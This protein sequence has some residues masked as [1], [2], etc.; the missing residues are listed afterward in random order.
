ML[1][2]IPSQM[3]E[4]DFDFSCFIWLP[5][6]YQQPTSKIQDGGR[7]TKRIDI[8][9]YR[10]DSDA[11]SMAISMFSG[12]SKSMVQRGKMSEVSRRRKFKM[13]ASK[14]E[15]VISKLLYKMATRFQRLTPCFMGPA[16]Q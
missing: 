3:V 16:T 14:P 9:G 8:S 15:V 2:G 12:S 11:I 7:Q 1:S 4:A 10:L 13:A 6:T 5:A